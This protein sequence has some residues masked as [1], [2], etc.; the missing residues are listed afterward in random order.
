MYRVTD[1]ATGIVGL[2]LRPGDELGF[3]L[4][5]AATP[6]AP[7]YAVRVVQYS[8]EGDDRVLVGG[9][10]FAVGKVKGWS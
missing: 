2:H 9:Q 8:V 5:L 7:G 4:E 1:P 10:T 3:G 6:A